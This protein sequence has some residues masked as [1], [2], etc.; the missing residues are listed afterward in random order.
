LID[1]GRATKEK[2]DAKGMDLR[3][4]GGKGVKGFELNSLKVI[5]YT[6]DNF[7]IEDY[8]T[9]LIQPGEDLLSVIPFCPT[10]VVYKKRSKRTD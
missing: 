6:S 10:V 9:Q 5:S 3:D 1:L 7:L 8:E 2:E 4:T